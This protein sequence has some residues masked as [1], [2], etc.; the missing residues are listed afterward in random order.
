MKKILYITSLLL[1]ISVLPTACARLDL[2]PYNEVD[3][4][5]TFNSKRDAELWVNGMYNA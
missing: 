4:S 3:E 1:V 5:K 2:E